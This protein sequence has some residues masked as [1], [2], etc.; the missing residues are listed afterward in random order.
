MSGV[1]ESEVM[2]SLTVSLQ[3][4]GSFKCGRRSRISPHGLLCALTLVLGTPV[5][6]WLLYNPSIDGS[7]TVPEGYSRSQNQAVRTSTI[8]GVQLGAAAPASRVVATS[9]VAVTPP[10]RHH[11]QLLLDPALTSGVKAPTFARSAPLR[12]GFQTSQPAVAVA[13]NVPSPVALPAVADEPPDSLPLPPITTRDIPL[14]QPR[15][16]PGAFLP[17][18]E[19]AARATSLA[20]AASPSVTPS[21]ATS[22]SAQPSFF[23]KLFGGVRESSTVLAYAAP[24]DGGLGGRGLGERGWGG[25]LLN[26]TG[27]ERTTA[28]YNIATHTVT[29]PDGTKLEAH[30]GLGA[31]LDDPRSVTQHMRGATPPNVYDLEPRALLFHGVKALRLNPIGGTTYGRLGLLA[32]TFMLGS[33]GDSNGCVVFRNYQAFLSAYE[34]GK[35]TRLAVV[36]GQ[37]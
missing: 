22:P 20:R 1:A 23:E 17:A 21:A 35:V 34:S 37:I 18:Y 11:L 28:V 32:H 10:L 3:D 31:S 29:L 4:S 9:L 6:L 2:T 14:P 36:A 13:Q 12:A 15:P 8:S 7:S 5:G 24:E 33:R 16:R 25:A 27:P 19:V 30:S 26:R